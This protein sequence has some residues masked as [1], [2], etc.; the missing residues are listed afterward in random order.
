MKKSHL[1]ITILILVFSTLSC[2]PRRYKCGPY[3]KCEN[4]IKKQEKNTY[5][6]EIVKTRDC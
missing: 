4:S 2:G 6:K 3:R 1:I 5:F